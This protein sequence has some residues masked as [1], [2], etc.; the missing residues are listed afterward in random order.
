MSRPRRALLASLWFAV[1]FMVRSFM[2]EDREPK[3]ETDKVILMPRSKM[4]GSG[5][6][7]VNCPPPPDVPATAFVPGL[8]LWRSV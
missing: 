2:F 8:D 6:I 5:Q 3:T 7:Y 1:G 4:Q